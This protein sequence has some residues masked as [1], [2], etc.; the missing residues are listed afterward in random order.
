MSP[1]TSDP[2]HKSG[3]T[4]VARPQRIKTGMRHKGGMGM[5]KPEEQSK[6]CFSKRVKQCKPGTW[7]ITPTPAPSKPVPVVVLPR[8]AEYGPCEKQNIP[9]SQGTPGPYASPRS[10]EETQ[11]FPKDFGVPKIKEVR[12]SVQPRAHQGHY[13]F[14]EPPGSQ[15]QSPDPNLWVPTQPH[16]IL[17]LELHWIGNGP[18]R[19][20]EEKKAA[21][22]TASGPPDELKGMMQKLLQGQQVQG[23]ALN[24]VTTEINTRMDNMFTELNSKYD[25][26]ASYIRQMD[27][28]ITQTAETIKRQQG[29]LP[30]KTDKNPKDRNA[31][32]LR[33]GRHLSDPIPKKLTAQ[34]KGKQKEGEQPPFEDVYDDEHELEQPSVPLSGLRTGTIVKEQER[35]LLRGAIG[36]ASLSASGTFPQD[37]MG[38]EK[39]LSSGF[40]RLQDTIRIPELPIFY[41]KLGVQQRQT[42]VWSIE[43]LQTPGRTPASGS[44]LEGTMV[45]RYGVF[46]A[47]EL[48][49]EL[50]IGLL[51]SFMQLGYLTLQTIDLPLEFGL[52]L[53]SFGYLI[54]LVHHHYHN[55]G[56][57]WL[58]YRFRVEFERYNRGSLYIVSLRQALV[59]WSQL[60]SSIFG[61]MEGSPY[62]KL[63]FSR[64][65]E[66]VPGTGPGVLRNGEPGYLLA[67]I[68]RPV[69]CLGSGGIQYLSNMSGSKG[70]EALA[71]YKRALEVRSAKK[72]APKRAAPSETEDEVQ[73]IR[74]NKRR[75]T[76]PASSS[77]NKLKASGSTP[78]VSPSS[79]G[80]PA[81]V[82]ANIN[83]KTELQ[84]GRSWVNT[85]NSTCGTVGM[86]G[87]VSTDGLISMIQREII[88]SM[89]GKISEMTWAVGLA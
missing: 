73:F 14:K 25:A 58:L 4:I 18:A 29:T 23:K 6:F 31:V 75:A 81:T 9:G 12:T 39:G 17:C 66:A 20:K 70:E 1:E 24:Q 80:D 40:H 57:G 13:N 47:L 11:D 84:Y 67:G 43:F 8:K 86:I 41:K 16:D 22:A 53:G 59:G 69:F 68:Q 62:R 2:G 34:E 82:L 19:G 87:W 5:G 74:S 89:D 45:P 46:R 64:G 33:N 88:I 44:P 7:V 52:S 54:L 28:Q 79:S 15:Q 27:V 35:S 30:G 42:P 60:N 26:I 21:P 36:T 50:R 61:N 38:D 71:E 85:M 10:K 32:E 48:R 78:K 77:M 37:G 49:G 51:L 83:T 76:V 56:Q 65:K 63:S 72:A 55:D 3:T